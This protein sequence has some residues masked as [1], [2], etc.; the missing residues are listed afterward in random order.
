M[1]VED[2]V[3]SVVIN[4]LGEE[5]NNQQF[6]TDIG[7]STMVENDPY[8]LVNT[9]IADIVITDVMSAEE[10]DVMIAVECKGDKGHIK[11]IGQAISYSQ[12]GF[13]SRFAAHNIDQLTIDM[14]YD[15]P[16]EKAYNVDDKGEVTEINVSNGEQ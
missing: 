1:S 11:G 14:M 8:P 5:Y 3:Q 9:K 7:L 13:N 16:I 2:V 15:T 4:R 10:S 6:R 12:Y